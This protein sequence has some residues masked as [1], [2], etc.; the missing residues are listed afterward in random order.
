MSKKEKILLLKGCAGL[1][2]RLITLTSAIAYCK[3]FDRRLII[4][5]NDGLYFEKGY[6]FFSDY[7]VLNNINYEAPHSTE[8]KSTFKSK[9]YSVYPDLFDNRI[10]DHLY[11]HFIQIMNP[12]LVKFYFKFPGIF[13]AKFGGLWTNNLAHKD[14]PALSI[15][16]FLKEKRNPNAFPLGGNLTKEYNQDILIFADYRPRF[17]IELFRRT[18]HIKSEIEEKIYSKI[19]KTSVVNSIGVHVR[20]TDMQP[21]VSIE[22]L[23]DHIK[24]IFPN[25]N[26]FLA[27]DNPHVETQFREAGIKMI[28]IAK[29]FSADEGRGIHQVHSDRQNFSASHES[30]LNSIADMFLLSR[31]DYLLYQGNS[32]FSILAEAMRQN[33]ANSQDW[34]KINS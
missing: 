34:L 15:A 28:S 12:L 25:K 4:D 20:A 6:N 33:K 16:S 14:N 1:G 9:N 8:L 22:D 3:K 13:G 23:I 11:D 27:T 30:F 19:D 2:N 29:D 26:V 5:W 10:E 21:T 18:F 32:S 31:T 7:F 17:D 24:S